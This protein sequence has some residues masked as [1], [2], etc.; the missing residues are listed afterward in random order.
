MKKIT[1]IVLLFICLLQAKSDAQSIIAG[2]NHSI[3]VCNDGTVRGWGWNNH[4]QVGDSTYIDKWIPTQVMNGLVGVVG[5]AGGF[6]H[7]LAVKSD[8]TMRAWG[9]GMYGQLGYGASS[10]VNFPVQVS[11]LMNVINAAA[12]EEHSL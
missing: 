10:N 6:D 4:G 7:T 5:V 3:A 11:G 1:F 12:G 8:G 9:N 2:G